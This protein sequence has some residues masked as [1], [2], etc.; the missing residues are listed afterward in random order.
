MVLTATVAVTVGLP[1][2]TAL[3]RLG[4]QNSLKVRNWKLYSVQIIAKHNISQNFWDSSG[5]HLKIFKAAGWIHSK[6]RKSG[7][8]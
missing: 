2:V 6:A 3:M 4:G 5:I 7:A 8:M 1:L